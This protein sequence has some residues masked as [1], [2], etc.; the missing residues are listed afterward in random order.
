MPWIVSIIC[1]FFSQYKSPGL[2]LA[3]L[4]LRWFFIEFLLALPC[5]LC[6]PVYKHKFHKESGHPCH[7]CL[8]R[9]AAVIAARRICILFGTLC[10]IPNHLQQAGGAKGTGWPTA[11]STA[12]CGM[13]WHRTDAYFLF[14]CRHKAEGLLFRECGHWQ[15]CRETAATAA[16]GGLKNG[17]G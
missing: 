13:F 9:T 6:Y 12:L 10:L 11:G 7:F 4:R 3:I 8:P 2:V 16:Q 5:P 15:H 17:T 14:P 1:E